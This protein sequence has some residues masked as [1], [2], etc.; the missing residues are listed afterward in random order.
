MVQF[1]NR[2]ILEVGMVQ[3]QEDMIIQVI[4]LEMV[5]LVVAVAGMAVAVAVQDMLIVNQLRLH[6]R[7]DVY[8][9]EDIIW[10][11]VQFIQEIHLRGQALEL[12]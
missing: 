12:K 10:L 3:T 5:L 11:T 6:I 2:Q 4:R 9:M 8:L 1:H 7:Q